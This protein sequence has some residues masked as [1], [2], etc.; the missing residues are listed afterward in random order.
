M[1]VIKHWYR[2]TLFKERQR[3]KDSPYN[4]SV[5][6]STRLDMAEYE[7]TG[8]VKADN[9]ARKRPAEEEEKQ[10]SPEGKRVRVEA[11]EE[12]EEVPT[13]A[14]V[15]RLMAW[16]RKVGAGPSSEQLAAAA[17]ECGLSE[18]RVLAWLE[19]SRLEDQHNLNL[20]A[21]EEIVAVR[22]PYCEIIFRLRSQL[23]DHLKGAHPEHPP[24]DPASLPDG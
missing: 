8:R 16:Y 12:V 18:G 9:C 20:L 24:V 2:N 11:P 6:P 17:A 13:M 5:P 21:D 15:E 3:D 14:Q 23:A 10:E 1:K 22:C 4:F 7:R 19:R